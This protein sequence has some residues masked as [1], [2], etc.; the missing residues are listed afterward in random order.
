MCLKESC[1]ILL[2]QHVNVIE[3]KHIFGM[4]IDENGPVSFEEEI[5]IFEK[6]HKEIR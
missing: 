5:A 4:V 3:W 1:R 2:D 6:V